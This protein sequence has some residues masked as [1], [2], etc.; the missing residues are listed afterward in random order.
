M[1]VLLAEV[2]EHQPHEKDLPNTM[3]AGFLLWMQQQSAFKSF[4]LKMQQEV[5][6]KK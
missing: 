3:D 4:L 5:E 6:F 2:V 1:A